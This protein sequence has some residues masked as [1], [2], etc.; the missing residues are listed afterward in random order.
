[1]KWRIAWTERAL[2]D[3]NRLDPEIRSRIAAALDRY[4][5][6]R[7]SRGGLRALRGR[8]FPQRG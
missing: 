1:V 6:G 2:R 4:A 5:A 3:A 7:N 8:P